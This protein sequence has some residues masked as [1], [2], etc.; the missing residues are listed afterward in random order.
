MRIGPHRAGD[1]SDGDLGARGAKASAGP[2]HL[3]EMARQREAE[4][5]RLGMNAVRAPDHR[6]ARMLGR[7]AIERT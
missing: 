2:L 1:F 4:S 6:R 3:R 5:D 7:A